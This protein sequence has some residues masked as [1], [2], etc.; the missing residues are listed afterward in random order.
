MGESLRATARVLALEAVAAGP[1]LMVLA[2][3]V[4]SPGILAGAAACLAA[5]YLLLRLP[6]A[7]P[8][9][10]GTWLGMA[11]GGGLGLAYAM[12]AHDVAVGVCAGLGCGGDGVLWLR[13]WMIA[14]V[15]SS[16][17]GLAAGFLANYDRSQRDLR[18]R[19]LAGHA[20]A[21]AVA[22]VK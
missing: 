9:P 1:T 7:K 13:S 14:L 17:I 5:G 11:I 21:H 15:A 19:R 3:G 10:E 22:R 18:A 12:D 20:A 8:V 2:W 6:G 16:G 4:R